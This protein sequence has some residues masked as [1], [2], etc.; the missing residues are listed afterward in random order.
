MIRTNIAMDLG[1]GQ[2]VHRDLMPSGITV[3]MALNLDYLR[4]V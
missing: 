1:P 3:G 2:L 4:D